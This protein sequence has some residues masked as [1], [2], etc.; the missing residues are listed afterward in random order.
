MFGALF[1][2][3]MYTIS[4]YYKK[5]EGVN[6]IKRKFLNWMF[7]EENSIPNLNIKIKKI[8]LRF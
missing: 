2:W 1:N 4:V 7:F 6:G 8:F 3:Q 5:T